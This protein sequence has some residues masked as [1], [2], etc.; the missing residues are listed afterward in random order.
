MRSTNK[1]LFQL[2]NRNDS[3]QY[4]YTGLSE[5]GHEHIQCHRWIGQYDMDYLVEQ[6]EWYWSAKYDEFDLN[7]LIPIKL[8]I[9][10][11]LKNEPTEIINQEISK[12]DY[13][14]YIYIER[15]NFPFQ[16]IFNYD[17][18]PNSIEAI[19][20]ILGQCYRSLGPS[21]HFNYAILRFTLNND[22]KHPIHQYLLSLENQIHI[23]LAND[24]Q[25]RHIRLS[26][27]VID[28][29]HQ[30]NQD[31]YVTFTLLDNPIIRLS[32]FLHERSSLELIRQLT[33][34]INDGN[35]YVRIDDG[36]F[37]LQ[38]RAESLRTL[39]L[40]LLPSENHTNYL[41]ET[42]FVYENVTQTIITQRQ[43]FVYKHIGPHI[44][45]LCTTSALLSLIATLAVGFFMTIRKWTPTNS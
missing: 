27:F 42:V 12:I 13:I 3:I 39:V 26:S 37:D 11:I 20:S 24:L 35:F 30:Q 32:N 33:R 2:D 21:H 34:Q 4:H 38:A 22:A 36:G 19:D 7:E 8:N 9:K 31:V 18:S 15:E 16:D 29:N 23:Q 5:C 41:N 17:P 25:I 44:V 6:Y 40:Y 28:I 10:T 43:K 14:S 1:L 45:A